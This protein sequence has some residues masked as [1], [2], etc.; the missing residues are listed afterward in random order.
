LFL[1]DVLH[2]SVIYV[3]SDSMSITPVHCV[4]MAKSIIMTF[5]PAGIDITVV[6][7]HQTSLHYSISIALLH[8]QFL[9]PQ[10]GSLSMCAI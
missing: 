3:S 4:K 2:A 5:S 6:F 1:G 10:V 7:S 9:H 8:L